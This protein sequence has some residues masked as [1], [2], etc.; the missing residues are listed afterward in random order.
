MRFGTGLG[1]R[2]QRYLCRPTGSQAHTF[3]AP[4]AEELRGTC[5]TCHRAWDKGRAVPRRSRFLLDQVLTF[6]L[7]IG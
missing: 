6:L 2:R 5:L 7:S 1:G 3:T 4:V